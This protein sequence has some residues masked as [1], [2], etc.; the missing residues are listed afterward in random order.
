LKP[1]L[2]I[3][4]SHGRNYL[5]VACRIGSQTKTIKSFGRAD[6]KENWEAAIDFL[7]ELLRHYYEDKMKLHIER[8]EVVKLWVR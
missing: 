1:Y 8:K 4:T 6:V 7:L 2:R 5:S 3:F